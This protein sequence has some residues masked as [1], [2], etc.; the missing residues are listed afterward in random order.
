MKLD[1]LQKVVVN[2]Y[3]TPMSSCSLKILNCYLIVACISLVLFSTSLVCAST[4]GDAIIYSSNSAQLITGWG[5]D[6]KEGG[7]AAGVTPA[8]ARTLFVTNRMNCL[9]IPIYGDASDPAHPSAGVVIGSY[10]ANTLYAM[11]NAR[12]ANSNIVLFA[13][14]K[15]DG[16]SSFPAWTE[17][18]NG[19]IPSQYATMLADYLQFMQS[20]GF[21][22]DVLGVD[23]ESSFNEGDITASAFNQIITNLISL[24]VSRGFTMPKAL[25]GPENYAPDTNWL[26]KLNKNGWNSLL[27]IVGTHYYPQIRPIGKLQ[28]LVQLAGALPVWNSEVHWQSLSSPADAIDEAQ[29]NIGTIFDCTDSGLNAYV[30]WAFGDAGVIQA[31][32]EQALTTSLV[33]TRPIYMDDIDGPSASIS[34]QLITR[35]FAS[36]SRLVVWAIN[37]STNV[38]NDYGFQLMRGAISGNVDYV[39]WTANVETTGSASITASNIFRLTLPARTVT[40]FTAPFNPLAALTITHL[41]NSISV[42]WPYPSSDFV[43][44][45]NGDL[46]PTNWVPSDFTVTTNAAGNSVT[47]TLPTT[48]IFFRLI[49]P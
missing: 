37:D 22:M 6:I 45:Q 49:A 42:S 34:G 7:K 32:M 16:Q 25:I 1:R 35:A 47:I 27:G 38:Y 29:Q 9:R 31:E 43:L 13:S 14:K 41:S 44:E 36:S 11:T 30:W 12:A 23:N 2:Y 3:W 10:Y 18:S 48:N 33:N 28:D 8:Y 39:Q 15:L 17:N 24:S 26:T 46:K 40:M 19:V 4:G 5:Y 21:T 20:N